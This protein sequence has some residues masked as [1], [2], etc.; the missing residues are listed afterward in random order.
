VVRWVKFK[1][2]SELAYSSSGKGTILQD[3]DL[4]ISALEMESMDA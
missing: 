2:A 3:W 4:K 1:D